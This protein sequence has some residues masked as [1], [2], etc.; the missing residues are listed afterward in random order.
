MC[1]DLSY[2][3]LQIKLAGPAVSA[4]AAAK[5]LQGEGGAFLLGLR[6]RES[7]TE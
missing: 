1:S 6:G 5:G 3:F 7:L 2:G 4:S